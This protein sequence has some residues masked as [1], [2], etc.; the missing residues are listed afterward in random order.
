[1]KKIFCLMLCLSLMAGCS[2]NIESSSNT[3]SVSD[4]SSVS[5]TSVETQTEY[6]DT[7]A[8]ASLTRTVLED[9][10]LDKAYDNLVEISN[11]NATL[12][13]S[14][15]EGYVAPES[16]YAQVMSVNIDGSVAMS[17][18]HA[19][20]VDK[21][22]KTITVVM[23]DGQTISNLTEVGDRGSIFVHGDAY[24]NLHVKVSDVVK[25]E[26]SDEAYENGEFNVSY[27]GKDNKLAEYT[28]TFDIM[29]IESSQLYIFD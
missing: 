11:D 27:S 24:Y 19:W 20:K 2:S 16:K 1:M 13:Q 5:K 17:T 28:V 6:V 12:A 26:Y 18:I 4:T 3:S 22:N 23:T 21:E 14:K 8:S 25:L 7:F 29:N 10:D 15:E 9:A